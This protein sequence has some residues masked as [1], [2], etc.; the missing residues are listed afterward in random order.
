MEMKKE[1]KGGKEKR[2]EGRNVKEDGKIERHDGRKGAWNHDVSGAHGKKSIESASK[3]RRSI[4][5]ARNKR[6]ANKKLFGPR[7]PRRVDFFMQ[8]Y[9]NAL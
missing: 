7:K 6:R 2:K 5:L 4:S 8:T 3:K 9:G 1:K